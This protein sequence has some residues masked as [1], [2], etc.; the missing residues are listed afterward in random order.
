MLCPEGHLTF[1]YFSQ[2]KHENKSEFIIL[3]S[4]Q[5]IEFFYYT[6]YLYL[7]QLASVVIQILRNHLG[8]VG[9]GC[10]MITSDNVERGQEGAKK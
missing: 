5:S 1:N 9:G 8:G 3:Q 10:Q 4:L 6:P 7:L 2:N